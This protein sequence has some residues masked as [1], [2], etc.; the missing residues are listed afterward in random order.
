MQNIVPIESQVEARRLERLRAELPKD[1]NTRW[2]ASRKAAVV[3]AV[4]AGA[5]SVAHACSR[6]G[7]SEEELDQWRDSLGKHGVHALLVT[8]MQRFR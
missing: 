5:I 4:D 7:L 1:P 8:K 3:S 6:F 2:V